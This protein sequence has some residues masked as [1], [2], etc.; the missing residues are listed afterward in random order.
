M[1]EGVE[2]ERGKRRR[3][4]ER[5]RER[6]R[7]KGEKKKKG[8]KGGNWVVVTRECRDSITVRRLVCQLAE[9]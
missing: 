9:A 5:E 6:E 7:R 1:E 8:K 3:E 2:G 4:R